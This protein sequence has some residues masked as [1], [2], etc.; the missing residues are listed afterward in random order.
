MIEV[1]SGI[2]KYGS[3]RATPIAALAV[4]LAFTLSAGVMTVWAADPPPA[5]G[6]G[7][8]P[9]G[10]DDAPAAADPGGGGGG[11]KRPYLDPFKALIE[12]KVELPPPTTV[13]PVMQTQAAAPPPVPPVNFKVNAVAGE[14]PNYVAVIEFEGQTYIVQ[15]G[16]KVPD[17]NP[18]FEVRNVTAEKVEVFDR[19]TSRIVQ[20]NLLTE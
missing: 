8:A 6:D 13:M 11:G 1:R 7:A 17:E 9:P 18:A 14:H 20:K 3:F 4:V 10:G 12:P 2:M 15:S 5:S 19:K 16:T